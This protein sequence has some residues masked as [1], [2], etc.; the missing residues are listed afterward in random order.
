MEQIMRQVFMELDDLQVERERL[1]D[2]KTWQG[3]YYNFLGYI[4][5]VYCVY[6]IVMVRKLIIHI[7]VSMW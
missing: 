4:F 2:S 7:I 1:R 5:S 6:K 3:K